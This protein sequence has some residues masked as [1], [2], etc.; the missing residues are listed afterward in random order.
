MASKKDNKRKYI[1]ASCAALVVACVAFVLYQVL[2]PD[3]PDEKTMARMVADIYLADAILQETG[4]NGGRDKKAENTYH[5]IL[6]NYGIN[7]V[8]YDSAVAWYSRHPKKF[9]SVYE[10]AVAIL[11]TREDMI[12]VIAERSD[13]ITKSIEAQNDSLTQD[14]IGTKLTI[15][16]PLTNSNDSLSSYLKPTTKKY[17]KVE[18]SFQLDSVMGG[19]FDI[20]YRYV[21][22]RADKKQ[23]IEL[24]KGTSALS[25]SSNRRAYAR[26]FISY[27]DSVVTCDSTFMP[28]LN[29]AVQKEVSLRANLRDSVPAT[30][31]RV[32]FFEE[33][34]LRDMSMTLREIKATY[35]PYDVV[36]TTSYDS[37][38]PSLFA[39]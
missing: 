5:T 33:D 9:S 24:H 4:T 32:V 3:V 34:K 1:I 25:Q 23:N 16:L 35:K 19:H 29:R 13:S 17:T 12:R 22:S 18:R 28:V 26:I 31:A 36:D 30:E 21:I 37:L 39:Y 7:K 8:Q 6:S 11:V 15:S 14:F 2:K 27:A 38:L 10:R 20:S